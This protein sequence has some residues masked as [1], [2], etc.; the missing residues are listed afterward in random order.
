[1]KLPRKFL[2]FDYGVH[3]LLGV[4]VVLTVV[5]IPL[6]KGTSAWYILPSLFLLGAWQLLS[7]LILTL[8]YQ[9]KMRALYLL[10]VA[11]YVVVCL[12]LENFLIGDYII[13]YG[14]PLAVW[15]AYLTYKDATYRTP[16]FWDLEF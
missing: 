1:M 3:I 5:L 7:A 14:M 10:A 2:K 11:I 12:L 8:G 9:D 16:S 13:F 6:T 15:Y 4:L